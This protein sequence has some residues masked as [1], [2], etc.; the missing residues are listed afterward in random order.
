MNTQETIS[1]FWVDNKEIILK[2]MGPNFQVLVN[3]ELVF[4]NPDCI[5]A[6][7]EFQGYAKLKNAA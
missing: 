7:E 4:S 3:Q 6:C 5:L 1:H 2:R